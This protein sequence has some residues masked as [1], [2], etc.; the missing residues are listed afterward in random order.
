MTK[1]FFA[2]DGLTFNLYFVVLYVYIVQ[3]RRIELPFHVLIRNWITQS[4]VWLYGHVMMSLESFKLVKSFRSMI[5][6][7]ADILE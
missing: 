3:I 5:T 2:V 1:S 7:K 4:N 6:K